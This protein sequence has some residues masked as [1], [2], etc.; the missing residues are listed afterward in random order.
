M[1]NIAPAVWGNKTWSLLHILTF[2]SKED[3]GK[4]FYY[5]QFIL[6]CEKCRRSYKEHI[7]ILPIPKTNK[8]EWLIQLHNRVNSSIGKKEMDVKDM[9]VYWKEQAKKITNKEIMEVLDFFVSVHPGYYKI[10]NDIIQGHLEL[11]RIILNTFP[12]LKVK[13]PLTELIISHK[14]EYQKWFK[15]NYNVRK[16]YK[17]TSFCSIL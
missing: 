1:Y 4:L 17:C 8:R 15:K 7:E 12:D 14:L 10:N 3:L 11:W 5:L 2:V 6:P 13:E 9:L 16:T